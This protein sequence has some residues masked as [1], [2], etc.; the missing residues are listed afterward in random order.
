MDARALYGTDVPPDPAQR[1][2]R[3]PAS[4]TL[5]GGN[6]RHLRVNG[7]EMI[8]AVAFLVRDRDWGTLTPTIRDLRI[9]EGDETRITY[10]AQYQAGG[11]HLDVSVVIRLSDT[12]L[13][14]QAEARAT[15]DFETN[16]TGFTVLHPISGVAGAPL[17]VEH[18][19]SPAEDTC[20]PALI[21][22][23]QPFQDI[24]ALIHQTGGLQ[25]ECRFEGDVF[26]MEDQRQWGDA[27]F[28]TYVR[29]LALPWPYQIAD[30]AVMRQA[31][32]IRWTPAMA[33]QEAEPITCAVPDARFPET[34]LLLTGAEAA[35]PD[36]AVLLRQIAP[37]RLL[38]HL[39]TAAGQGGPEL[40][41]FAAL[42]AQLPEMAFDLE[43]IARCPV[44]G[45]LAAEFAAYAGDLAAAG[46]RPASVMVCPA[47]DRQSTPPGSAWP[48]CPPLEAIHAAARQAF[49]GITLGGGMAS[50]FPELNRKRPPAGMLDFVTHGF[51]PIVHAADDLSVMETLETLPHILRSARAILGECT[52]RLGPSTIAMRQN[53]YGSRTIPN[54]WRGRVCMAD[55]DPRQDGAFAAAWTLG[56]ATRIAP[57]GV[58]VWTPAGL[59]GPRGLFRD[60]GSPRPLAAVVRAL[61]A[62]AGQPVHRAEVAAGRAR[63]QCGDQVFTA[64]LTPEGAFG[65]TAAMAGDL[66]PPLQSSMP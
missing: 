18:G 49:P 7:A 3:G 33:G 63:L 40:R 31:V 8:R 14:F 34:A 54:P 27:S 55:D 53:P 30:G 47:V 36:A 52:Y 4:V 26:E 10:A 60:D 20:F 46:L 13:R 39:D 65:W 51:C 29:P 62:C 42:Q 41:A 19:S 44:E 1:L 6:L 32:Q 21:E 15:G 61:A 66:Q 17:R 38:C 56:F 22:P 11:A 35:R 5:E 16:R 2:T 59:T 25:V 50:F 43:L 28:K 37:Q 58:Q 64:D 24:T 12:A 57:A 48:P 9:A 23:W 45:D